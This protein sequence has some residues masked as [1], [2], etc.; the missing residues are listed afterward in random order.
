MSIRGK[1]F[2]A[3]AYEHPDRKIP[4]QSVAQVH[5]ELAVGL[6]VE[7]AFHDTG[8]G[9]ALPRFRPQSR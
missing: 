1:A 3:G 4:G 8:A 6:P 7:V 2:I 9:S 5:A